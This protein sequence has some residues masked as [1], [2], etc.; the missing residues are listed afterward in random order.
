MVRLTFR[1]LSMIVIHELNTAHGYFSSRYLFLETF[2]D[3]EICVS[4][5]LGISTE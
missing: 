4:E 1:S 3:F 5:Q 2:Q